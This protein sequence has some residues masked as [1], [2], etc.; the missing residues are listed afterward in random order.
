MAVDL[1]PTDTINRLNRSRP[2]LIA[3]AQIE[4]DGQRASSSPGHPPGGAYTAR[5][6]E[7]AGVRPIQRP[8]PRFL[9]SIGPTRFWDHEREVG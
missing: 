3:P 7:M 6:G 1:P 4:I 9:N 5:G 2:N 8:D